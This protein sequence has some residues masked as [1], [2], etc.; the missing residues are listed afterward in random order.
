MFD[1][2]KKMDVKHR[3]TLSFLAIPF[4]A[5]LIS[6]IHIVSFFAL[7]NPTWMSIV[8]AFTFEVGSLASLV[9]FSILDKLKKGPIYF[10]FGVLF[11]MQIMGNVYF[12]FDYV[13]RKLLI[14]GSWINILKEFMTT[15]YNIFSSEEIDQKYIKFILSCVIGMPIPIISISFI[16]TLVDY[17][18]STA[19]K[20]IKNGE[21]II[22]SNTTEKVDHGMSVKL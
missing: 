10:I 6:T 1:F 20:P 19:E 5:S 4:L 7:A 22:K 8:L 2:I 18:D 16:K 17:L 11:F 9:S 15:A 12:S 14:D 3:I 21:V 13:S